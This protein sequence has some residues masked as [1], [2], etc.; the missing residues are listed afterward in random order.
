MANTYTQLYIQFVF[1]VK[2]RANLIKESFRCEFEKIISGIVEN[3][4]CKLL[5][6]YSNPDHTHLFVS[7]HPTLSPSKLMEQVK[8]GSSKWLNEKKYLPIPFSWQVGFGAFT[9]SK[10]QIDTIVKYI[11]NQPIHHKKHSFREEYLQLLK[12]FDIEYNDKYLFDFIN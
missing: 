9:Y 10:N 3:H 11:L 4:R 6:I 2:N 1:V 5:A 12:E 8:S 7:M